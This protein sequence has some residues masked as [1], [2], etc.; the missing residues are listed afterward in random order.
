[1]EFLEHLLKSTQKKVFL[2]LHDLR[3]H[4]CKPAKARFAQNAPCMEVFH[5]PS[6]AAELN[7]DEQLN[8]TL[9]HVSRS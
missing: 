7:P 4:H 3:T 1:M 2:I 5:L 9:K 8:A 6:Y